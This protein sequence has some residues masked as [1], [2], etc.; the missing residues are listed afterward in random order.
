MAG[1]ALAVAGGGAL[2]W[3][4][5]DAWLNTPTFAQRY[6][7]RRGA[8]QTVSLPDAST[9]QLDTD[10]HV[11]ARFFPNRREVHM[12]RGQAMFAVQSDADAPFHVFARDVTVTVVGTRFAVRCTETGLEPG[13]VRV[14]V[15]EG[16][17]RV[18]SAA[19]RAAGRPAIALGAGQSIATDADGR[20]GPIAA[21]SP[22]DVGAWREG[23]VR[24]DNTTLARALQE[25]E[26]YVPTGV[27]IGDASVAALRLTGSFDVRHVASF[28]QALPRVLPV[29]IR[30]RGD[31]TEIV[32][33]A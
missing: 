2:G 18:A 28:V 15:E 14:D 29:R 17:V 16:R 24:F 13:N 3:A 6:D 20:F 23:R 4:L 33:A 26:R 31:V 21:I 1:T 8:L 32:R 10:T 19:P 22:A 11:E 27:A 5:R 30:T 12:Q 25:F 9:L 7:T